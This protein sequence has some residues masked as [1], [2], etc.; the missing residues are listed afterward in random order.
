MALFKTASGSLANRS[1][2]FK[3]EFCKTANQVTVKADDLTA[4]CYEN[5]MALSAKA[6]PGPWFNCF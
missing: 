1:R 3:V 2:H 6:V 4:P 5:L